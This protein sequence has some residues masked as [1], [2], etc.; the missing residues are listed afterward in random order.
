MEESEGAVLGLSTDTELNSFS[1]YLH[2]QY[3][4]FD[5][6]FTG[7]GDSKIQPE[8]MKTAELPNVEVLK[9][10]HHGSKYGLLPEFLELIK[11]ELAVVSVGKN[12]Y[13]HPT[14]EALQLLESRSIKIKRTDIGGDVEVVSDGRNWRMVNQSQTK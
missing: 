8:I 7:D 11:P 3:G 12:S 9:F 6:L 1:Y 14:K 10:P 13:G 2:L 5:A 4:E